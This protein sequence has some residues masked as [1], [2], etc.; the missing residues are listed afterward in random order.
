[1]DD[2]L[3]FHL[4]METEANM[5]RGL[6]PDAA[7][8]AALR[9]FGGVAQAKEEIRDV[10]RLPIEW[11][12]H[13]ARLALRGLRRNAGFSAFAIATL[14]LG[15][16]VNTAATAVVYGVLVRP[17]P[18]P[19]ASRIV[20][21]N[22]HFADGG[23]LGFSPA[24]LQNWLPRLQAFDMAAGYYSRD[25]TIRTGGTSA[26]MPAAFV[27]DRFFDVLGVP[28][29]SG[30]ASIAIA[31]QEIVVG[32]RAL[33]EHVRMERGAAVGAPVSIGESTY[34]I[35]GTMPADFAFPN[36]EVGLWVPSRA[37]MAGT[38][39]EQSGYSKIVGRLKPEVTLEGARRDADRVRLELNP[40]SRDSVSITVLGET[41][42]GR[43]RGALMASLAGAL[44]VLLVACANVA[45]LFIGRNMARERELA[46][47][48]ALGAAP[49]RIVCSVIIEALTI[50]VLASLAGLAVGAA[51]LKLFLATA[52]QGL[53]GLDRV[54]IDRPVFFVIAMLTMIVTLACGAVPAWQASRI[55]FEPF[56]RSRSALA[57]QAWRLRAVLVVAQ[58]ALSCVLLIGA[59]L[60]ARTVVTVMLE[61]HGFDANGAI[62]ARMLLSNEV[63]SNERRNQA[64]VRDVLDRVRALPG[65]QYAGFGTSLPPRA[66]IATMAVS[67]VTDDRKESRFFNIASG[68][69][70]YLRAMGARFIAG[71]D[72]AGGSDSTGLP[73]VILSESAARFFFPKGDAIGGQIPNLPRTFGIAAAP[74]VIGVVRDIK[75]EGLD[76]PP[77]ATI[78]LNWEQRPFGR[79]YLIVRSKSNEGRLAA[80]IR[81]A[82]E[83]IDSSIPIAELQSLDA[84]VAESIANRR[85]RAVPAMAFGVLAVV[86]AFAGLL[87]TLLTLVAERRRDFA[88]RSA[89][90]A[91]PARLMWTVVQ[92]GLPLAG[93]GLLLGIGLGGVAARSLSSF[94]YRVSP[95]DPVTFAATAA[96]V[97]GG[98]FL[99]T[100]FAAVR[101]RSI[102]P[103]S[104]LRCE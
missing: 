34:T 71:R 28:A 53:T 67:V 63:L 29:E 13:D 79:G 98:A 88:V 37:L 87:A 103:L 73:S 4:E 18:Y 102:N 43:V 44:V 75:Y 49:S 26:V 57:P 83:A 16:G 95:Y 90:G 5:G 54:A 51:A 25:I 17:L 96:F 91:T 22:L 56:L 19:D 33:A 30:R 7:R 85:I 69:S 72:F 50:A 2:E 59:G 64:F 46:A 68:T 65:V 10:R 52:Q 93:A 38:K 60:L 3:R 78:Y 84:A 89:I 47:R 66:P 35:R 82:A 8:R 40:K 21:L 81:R 39:S 9:D 48:V 100:F 23:D 14:A 77:G 55:S 62:E 42:A 86:V 36:D 6:S 80:E 97:G 76:A 32:H 15:V 20:V 92:L 11:L 41:A 24:A 70:G 104:I 74:Q 1:M 101:V 12:W 27:T 99:T 31:S 94:L 58:I 45:T 61:D